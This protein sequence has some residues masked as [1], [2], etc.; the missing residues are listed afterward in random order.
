V[1]DGV[2]CYE[3]NLFIEQRT[4]IRAET[5][6]Q[7]PVSP[8]TA[9]SSMCTW[10]THP[11]PGSSQE[12]SADSALEMSGET[13]GGVLPEPDH[14]EGRRRRGSVTVSTDSTE[15]ATEILDLFDRFQPAK[16]CH[17]PAGTPRLMA[18]PR[19][20]PPTCRRRGPRPRVAQRCSRQLG[21]LKQNR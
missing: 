20:W 10:P 15:G 12:V 21:V 2:Q 4:K 11:E 14:T 8:S 19:C 16:K 5:K 7:S 17:G 13:L 3:Y 9:P 6:L 1:Q 18:L